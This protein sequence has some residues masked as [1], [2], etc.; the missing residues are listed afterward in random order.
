MIKAGSVKHQISLFL[1]IILLA[2]CKKTP[3]EW[4]TNLNAPLFNTELSVAH[5]LP[6][7]MV[8]VDENNLLSLV[9]DKE[10][11][12]LSTN[13]FTSLPDSI[14]QLYLPVSSTASLAPNTL[15]FHKDEVQKMKLSPLEL[16]KIELHGGSIAFEVINPFN[17]PIEL[18]YQ[19]PAAKINGVSLSKKI[20]IP[21]GNGSGNSYTAHIDISGY[22]LDLRG[23]NGNAVNSYRNI[24]AVRVSPNAPDSARTIGSELLIKIHFEDIDLGYAG[25]FFG[26]QHINYGPETTPIHFFDM[27]QDGTLEMESAQA[28]FSIQNGIGA[29]LQFRLLSLKAIKSNTLEELSFQSSL[30]NRPINITR[31]S[32][33]NNPG[34]P[35][36]PT[37]TTI[38]ITESNILQWLTFFPDQTEYQAMLHLNPM[39][40]ISAG[41]DFIY[42]GYDFKTQVHIEIPFSF[43]VSNLTLRDDVAYTFGNE[44]EQVDHPQLQLIADN[45]YPFAA[46]VQVEILDTQGQSKLS[47]F[48]GNNTILPGTLI[49][50][51][52]STPTRSILPITLNNAESKI[53]KEN[54]KMRI[55]AT[56]NTNTPGYTKIY[57]S[58]KLR[59]KLTGN[60]QYHIE[61]Q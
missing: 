42:R 25:G 53:L 49:E 43:A 12:S 16:T 59:L 19:I 54:G 58:Y 4:D 34:T 41:N 10:L 46:Q 8:S 5:I 14:F 20:T 13:S 60:F 24:L 36:S 1:I 56:F 29:D 3:L 6:D 38:D 15:F 55:T 37:T 35:V 18:H 30:L 48:S 2:G 57:D 33:N 39:G 50:E 47:L 27:I 23:P 11:F 22:Q 52:V 26:Q 17:Q 40:N 9:I 44:L 32:E 61:I 45:G 28:S 7:S 51:G 21:K 31:A